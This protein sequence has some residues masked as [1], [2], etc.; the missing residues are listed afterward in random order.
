[1]AKRAPAER[2]SKPPAAT[3]GDPASGT[4]KTASRS[5]DPRSSSRVAA[6]TPHG[7]E[8]DD[9]AVRLGSR[10]RDLRAS[11]GWTQRAAAD[12]I[13]IGAAVVRRLEKGSANPSL[14]ILV[15]VARAFGIPLRSLLGR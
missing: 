5:R 4:H 15:S 2:S 7:R 11:K 6:A 13:G 12:R 9:L 14:A 3:E 10:L 1:M 8:F